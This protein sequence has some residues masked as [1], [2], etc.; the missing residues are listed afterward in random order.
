MNF[1]YWVDPTT[2][3]DLA[4][5]EHIQALPAKAEATLQQL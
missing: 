1:R 2:G 4:L 5:E 3:A